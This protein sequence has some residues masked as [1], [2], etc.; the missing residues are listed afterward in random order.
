MLYIVSKNDIR[1]D[2]PFIDAVP[3]FEVCSSRELKYIFL[4]YD[5][6]SP[7]KGLSHKDRQQRAAVAAGFKKEKGRSILDRNARKTINGEIPKV[8][9]AIIEFAEMQ[10]DLDEEI[11]E[12]INVQIEQYLEQIKKLPEGKA[13]WDL[14][15][16]LNKAL[17]DLVKDR[18]DIREI[19]GKR[20]EDEDD[21]TM[22]VAE[23][24]SLDKRNQDK[25]DKTNA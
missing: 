22:S 9:A 6:K 24:S 4:T 1:E 18:H 20:E 19:L 3:Q 5:Y 16:K 17:K 10:Y 23:L 21:G 7:Y 2:N 13:E 15:I 14:R 8:Q 11:L 25:V 12:A